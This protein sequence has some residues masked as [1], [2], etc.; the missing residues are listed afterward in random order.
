MSRTAVSNS[1]S[2][3][4]LCS[5][6]AAAPSAARCSPARTL[7]VGLDHGAEQS[8]AALDGKGLDGRVGSDG[9]FADGGAKFCERVEIYAP[10]AHRRAELIFDLLCYFEQI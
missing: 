2:C 6:A 8:A 7:R 3:R 1:T 5:K 10:V 4:M 9:F